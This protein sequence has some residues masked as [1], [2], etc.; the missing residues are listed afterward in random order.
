MVPR[1]PFLDASVFEDATTGSLHSSLI[2]LV[3]LSFGRV[4]TLLAKT[5]GRSACYQLSP[6]RTG[7]ALRA[8]GLADELRQVGPHSGPN[9]PGGNPVAVSERLLDGHN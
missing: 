8:P 9:S 2:T 4:E 3:F 1:V 7:K 6:H 5:A